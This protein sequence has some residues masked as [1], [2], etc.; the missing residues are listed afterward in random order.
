[1]APT[2]GGPI[3]PA[4]EQRWLARLR[5]GLNDAPSRG[6]DDRAIASIKLSRHSR[7]KAPAAN[8][9]GVS[10]ARP[11]TRTQ[12]AGLKVLAHSVGCRKMRLFSGL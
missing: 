8:E 9:L 11:G 1:M 6:A 3:P 4:G 2:T 10:S 7:R 12:P 5:P